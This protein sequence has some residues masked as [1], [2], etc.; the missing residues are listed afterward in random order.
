MCLAPN[1][2]R[3]L[4]MFTTRAAVAANKPEEENK[5]AESGKD[6]GE[7]DE[8]QVTKMFGRRREEENLQEVGQHRV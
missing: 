8:N 6:R 7:G 3:N 1:K 2:K 5:E 4:K